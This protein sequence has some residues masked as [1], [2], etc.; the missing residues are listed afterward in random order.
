MVG[1]GLTMAIKAYTKGFN[2]EMIGKTGA[3]IVFFMIIT[4][5]IGSWIRSIITRWKTR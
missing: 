5:L 3:Y 4:G 2:S 1:T